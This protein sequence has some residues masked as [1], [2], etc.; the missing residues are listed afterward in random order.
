MVEAIE[1]CVDNNFTNE[2]LPIFLVKM[3][4]VC[5]YKGILDQ[6]QFWCEQGCKYAD[7]YAIESAMTESKLCLEKLEELRKEKITSNK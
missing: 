7:A 6:A 4:V 2:E 5:L 1:I 3:G